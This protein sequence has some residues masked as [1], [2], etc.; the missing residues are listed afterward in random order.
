MAAEL[1][2][3]VA[4]CIVL[5]FRGALSRDMVLTQRVGLSK[6]WYCICLELHTFSLVI[7][8]IFVLFLNFALFF[9]NTPK[10][11]LLWKSCFHGSAIDASVHG[12]ACRLL[13]ILGLRNMLDMGSSVGIAPPSGNVTFDSYES[14]GD[15]DPFVHA[16]TF[17][18]VPWFVPI[19][20]AHPG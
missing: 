1:G 17:L 9:S 8:P 19:V 15:A 5:G 14:V 2:L 7:C 20:G 3:A 6:R 13:C 16:D 4:A 18:N 12:E 11:R 10:W